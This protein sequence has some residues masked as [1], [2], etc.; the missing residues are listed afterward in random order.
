MQRLSSTQVRVTFSSNR[1]GFPTD[2]SSF[3]IDTTTGPETIDGFGSSTANSVV[4]LFVQDPLIG[5]AWSYT[6][7]PDDMTFVPP[8]QGADSGTIT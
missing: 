4:L 8:L 5:G 3:Q 7:Q 2:W 1:I 6:N